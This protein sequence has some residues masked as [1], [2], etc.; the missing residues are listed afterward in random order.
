M[1]RGQSTNYFV[2]VGFV[3]LLSARLYSE[4]HKLREK[5]HELLQ[6]AATTVADENYHTP[7]YHLEA[8]FKLLGM[9]HHDVDGTYVNDF[10]KDEQW[11]VRVTAD[12]FVELRVRNGDHVWWKRNEDYTPFRVEQLLRSIPPQFWRLTDTDVV[13]SIDSSRIAGA[14]AT[15][16]TA[17]EVAGE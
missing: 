11:R 4:D 7:S 13:K 17:T 1:F 8:Q 6:K 16:I 14:T 5:A 15:C 12:D 2:T 9:E 3:A 10:K